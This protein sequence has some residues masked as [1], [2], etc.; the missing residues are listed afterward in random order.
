MGRR[1]K[2]SDDVTYYS[3]KSVEQKLEKLRYELIPGYIG[4]NKKTN[5]YN[6]NRKNDNKKLFK[7]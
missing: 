7:K 4:R 1:F 6:R 5:N 2:N 3:D